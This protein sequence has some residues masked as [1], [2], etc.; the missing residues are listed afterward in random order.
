MDGPRLLFVCTGNPARSQ[1]AEGFAKAW[2]IRA[3]SA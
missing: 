1:M 2:G 3:Q